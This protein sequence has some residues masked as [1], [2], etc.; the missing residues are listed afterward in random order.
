MLS[1]INFLLDLNLKPL[2]NYI[3]KTELRV[4]AIETIER[5][6]E[7]IELKDNKIKVLAK[8]LKDVNHHDEPKIQTLANKNPVII[9]NNKERTKRRL[10]NTLYLTYKC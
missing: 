9:I 7:E 8:D 4:A 6:D 3:Q 2:I 5:M 10:S 1:L